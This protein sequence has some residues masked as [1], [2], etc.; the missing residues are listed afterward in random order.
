MDGLPDLVV[1]FSLVH[2]DRDSCLFVFAPEY[3]PP[4]ALYFCATSWALRADHC[5]AFPPWVPAIT[6]FLILFLSEGLVY[7]MTL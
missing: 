3:P 5:P 7:V 4:A 6:R 1:H 2:L